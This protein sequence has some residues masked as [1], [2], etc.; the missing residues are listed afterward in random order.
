MRRAVFLDRDGVINQAVVR[1]GTPYP[2]ANI[3]ELVILPG[4]S[5]A[6]QKLHEENYLLIVVTNQPDVARGVTQKSDVEKINN[7]LLSQLPLDDIKTCYHD[8]ADGC[9]CRKPL[10][11]ALI[12]AAREYQ[13]NL[14]KSFMV[15]D[16]WRDIE[17]G[18]FAGCKTFFINYRYAEKQPE[19]PDF[20]VSSLLEAQQIICGEF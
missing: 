5:Q 16:R 10:P 12:D 15:G 1:N 13:I 18:Q 14:S 2:P 6:L 4:V 11:G 17:A 3:S 19:S 20:I 9:R 8:H 7:Y